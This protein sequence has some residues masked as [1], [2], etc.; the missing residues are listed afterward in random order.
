MANLAVGY[1]KG[2][3]SGRLSVQY[4]EKSL[5]TVGSRAELDGFTDDLIRWDLALSQQFGG[6]LSVFLNANNL[7]NHPERAFLGIEVL[8]TNEQ[9]FGWTMDLGVKYKF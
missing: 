7:S 1:E 8:P 3:F 6:G 5:F 4:Q 9:I 2:G